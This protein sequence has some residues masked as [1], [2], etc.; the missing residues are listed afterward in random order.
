MLTWP[1]AW[2]CI[3]INFAR[4]MYS[5]LYIY[6]NSFLVQ[7]EDLFFRVGDV[8]LKLRPLQIAYKPSTNFLIFKYF[9]F[10]RRQPLF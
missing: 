1:L 6:W 8:S 10:L 5:F 2:K 9:D 3:I 4:V 7:V